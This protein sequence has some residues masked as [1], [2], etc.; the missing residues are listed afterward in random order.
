MQVKHMKPRTNRMRIRKRMN[1][2]LE[3]P[4]PPNPAIQR[5]PFAR[6]R[7]LNAPTYYGLYYVNPLKEVTVCR[8]EQSTAIYPRAGPRTQ[9][10]SSERSP[11]LVRAAGAS[12][13]LT[14]DAS[15]EP[16]RVLALIGR[17]SYPSGAS[18]GMCLN[19]ATS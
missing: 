6:L 19:S 14:R 15:P 17:L 4:R 2:P 13:G 9:S 1:A 18:R 10:S 16:C 11:D 3:L 5:P 8:Q 12:M 7:L